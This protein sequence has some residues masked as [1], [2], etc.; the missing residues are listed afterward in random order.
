MSDLIKFKK[1]LKANLPRLSVGEP[2]FT[3]D[4]KGLY[5]GGL[6]DN[7]AVA[8]K[9]EVDSQLADIVQQNDFYTLNVMKNKRI[10][11]LTFNSEVGTPYSTYTGDKACNGIFTIDGTALSGW[12][13]VKSNLGTNKIKFNM[14][15]GVII[16]DSIAEGH[17]ALHGRLHN[18][19][20]DADLTMLNSPGQLAYHLEQNTKI[21]VYNHGIGGQRFDQIRARWNRDVLAQTDLA[22][23]PT[24]TLPKKPNF[25]TIVC[26]INDVFLP[27]TYADIIADAEYCIDSAIANNIYPIVFN[28]GTHTSMDATKLTLVKQYNAWLLEKSKRT[29]NMTMIDFYTY[30]NDPANDGKPKVGI[31]ADSVHP[32]KATYEDLA[33]KTISEGFVS[34]KPP[35]SPKFIN[36]STALNM[37][38]AMTTMARPMAVLLYINDIPVKFIELINEPNQVIKIPNFD[39]F[40]NTISIEPQMVDAPSEQPANTLT[41]CFMSEVYLSDENIYPSNLI[42]KECVIKPLPSVNGVSRFYPAIPTSTP[43]EFTFG[44]ALALNCVGTYVLASTTTGY[45]CVKGLCIA[46]TTTDVFDSDLLVTGPSGKFDRTISPTAGTIV[47]KVAK[48]GKTG[49]LRSLIDIF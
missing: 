27:R 7:I 5:I 46:N 32:T 4:E 18:S 12:A 37:N 17:P 34:N 15:V 29:P 40:I 11:P 19:N 10:I 13:F 22:L 25:V 48:A 38:Y 8:M 45:I 31:F 9:A 21:K 24:S 16:G 30:T 39:G 42:D 44:G 14:P 43:G 47:A 49:E 26:G 3:T 1:G 23:V 28:I 6:D 36:I 35:V 20:G 41:N 33:R 2:G